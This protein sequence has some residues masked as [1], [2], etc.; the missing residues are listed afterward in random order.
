MRRTVP[1]NDTEA[2]VAGDEELGED[3]EEGGGAAD[4]KDQELEAAREEVLEGRRPCSSRR[5]CFSL[6]RNFASP[7]RTRP[8]ALRSQISG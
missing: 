2:D 1:D 3:V 5:F 6:Y 7:S 4:E 8:C